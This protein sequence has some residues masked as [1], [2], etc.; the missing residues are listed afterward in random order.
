MGQLQ[1]LNE[2]TPAIPEGEGEEEEDEIIEETSDNDGSDEQISRVEITATGRNE[3]NSLNF[4]NEDSFRFI[5]QFLPRSDLVAIKLTCPDYYTLP[6]FKDLLSPKLLYEEFRLYLKTIQDVQYSWQ[7]SPH[8]RITH[9]MLQPDSNLHPYLLCTPYI[10]THNL[11]WF[12]F[13]TTYDDVFPGQYIFLFHT[14]VLRYRVEF[15]LRKRNSTNDEQIKW[16]VNQN[17]S[18]D[19]EILIVDVPDRGSLHIECKETE[20]YKHLQK[21]YYMLLIPKLYWNHLQKVLPILNG[22]Y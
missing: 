6:F 11:W 20:A 15:S 9:F 8:M 22:K 18:N 19:L 3:R 14:T 7:N 1:S 4:L 10:L 17:R 12:C 2:N 16:S 13:A 5:L 21:V